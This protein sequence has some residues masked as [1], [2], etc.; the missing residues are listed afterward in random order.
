MYLNATD[1]LGQP[2]KEPSREELQELLLL[3]RRD[4]LLATNSCAECERAVALTQSV[5]QDAMN[6]LA[7]CR[8]RLEAAQAALK[9]TRKRGG[10]TRTRR[11]TK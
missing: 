7:K 11:T 10:A 6:D 4:A 9:R 1:A 8:T 5:L 3:C 2:Q